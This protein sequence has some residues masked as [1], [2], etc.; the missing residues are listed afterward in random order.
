MLI[1]ATTDRIEVVLSASVTTNQLHIISSY[2]DSTS[3]AV[4]P[5]KTVTVTN[6]TTA[7]NMVPAPSAG[8]SRQLRY[9]NIF[10][11][12]TAPAT[13]TVR[14]NYN[15]TVRN[16]M[17]V[18]LYPNDY[19]QYTHRVGWKVFSF[20][21]QMKN[22]SNCIVVSDLGSQVFFHTNSTTA[23][24]TIGSGNFCGYLGKATGPYSTIILLCTVLA[25]GTL[26]PWFEIGI[27]KGTPSLGANVTLTRVAWQDVSG[28]FAQ[29]GQYRW[30]HI[31]VSD[32]SPG[33]NLWFVLS[34]GSGASV[35][36]RSATVPDD[37][38]AGFIQTTAALRLSLNSTLS[39]SLQSGVTLPAVFWNAL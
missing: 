27:Y 9:A 19:M 39:C 32:I 17:T 3:S 1:S 13:V 33:D 30:L 6:N 18:T 26:S 16:V 29:V 20:N 34:L 25:S 12:D 8:S 22:A 2:N 37:V 38:G 15:G 28:T 14:T 24:T 11:S 31:P 7:V 35:T 23:S 21:G 36:M 4:T 5:T 10:N